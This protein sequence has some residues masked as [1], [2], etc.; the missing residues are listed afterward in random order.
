MHRGR[1]NAKEGWAPRVGGVG[2]QGRRGK[3]VSIQ[4][5]RGAHPG[6]RVHRGQQVL[7]MAIG[8]GWQ[9]MAGRRPLV[10]LPGSQ[11]IPGG[12]CDCLTYMGATPSTLGTTPSTPG[13]T[14]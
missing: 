9:G 11:E 8:G 5:R 12:M 13:T 6:W 1:Q 10:P 4:G 3:R 7:G 2:T 14:A